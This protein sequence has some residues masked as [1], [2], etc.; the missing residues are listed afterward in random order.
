MTI[1][2]PNVIPSPSPTTARHPKPFTPNRSPQQPNITLTPVPISLTLVDSPVASVLSTLATRVNLPLQWPPI[3]LQPLRVSRMS[4]LCTNT[5]LHVLT[6]PTQP[7][8]TLT[9]TLLPVELQSLRTP[10]RPTWV[11]RIERP[12]PHS[13]LNPHRTFMFST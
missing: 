5:L 12:S 9:L 4:P 2:V 7:V 6:H 8:C 1:N 10:W 11:C 13:L 3:I